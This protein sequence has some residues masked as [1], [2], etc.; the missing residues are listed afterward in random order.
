MGVRDDFQ[1]VKQETFTSPNVRSVK[2]QYM[3]RK[4]LGTKLDVVTEDF[5]KTIPDSF[6]GKI[7]RLNLTT[8]KQPLN[9]EDRKYLD[10]FYCPHNEKL[11]EL[12][13][14]DLSDWK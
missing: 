8:G 7:V 2:A 14:W 10:D 1:P 6:L 9:E 5:R 12:L 11:E 4:I 13:G 3:F